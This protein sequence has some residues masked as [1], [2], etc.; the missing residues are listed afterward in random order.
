[1][2]IKAI[3]FDLDD[4]LHDHQ[5]PFANAL[6]DTF[7][8]LQI[9]ADVHTAYVGFRYFSDLLWPDYTNRKISLEQLRI[10]RIMLTLKSF[11]I[12]LT[13]DKARQFQKN[14][15]NNLNDLKL[16]SE[17][18]KL[19]N[20]LK[21]SGLELGLITNGPTSHQQNKI[22]QL[23]LSKF[24]REDLMFISDQVGYAKPDPYIFHKASQK[25]NIPADHLLYIG[26]SWE[27]DVV[28]PSAAGWNSVWF[29]HRNREPLTDHRPLAVVKELS[30]LLK[31]LSN[32]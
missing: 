29:N 2:K 22:R 8:D 6:I 10:D 18:P 21:M 25:I 15:E 17:V 16:F 23:N 32:D 14:Y 13:E 3:F 27:N 4:T 12:S 19:F 24:I 11:G 20:E 9:P 7:N 1:M 26:D 5:A 31:V 28:G 30:S